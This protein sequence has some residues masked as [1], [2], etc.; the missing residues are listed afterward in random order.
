MGPEDIK[1]DFAALAAHGMI[2]TFGGDRET[3]DFFD[4]TNYLNVDNDVWR[5]RPVGEE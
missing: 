3:F 4:L 5:Y 2:Y 1:Y